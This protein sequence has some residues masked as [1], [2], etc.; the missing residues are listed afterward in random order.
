MR[1]K[2]VL[3]IVLGEFSQTTG[4][5]DGGTCG[6]GWRTDQDWERRPDSRPLFVPPGLL[7]PLDRIEWS[8]LSVGV[9]LHKRLLIR[10]RPWR[11]H[12]KARGD[13]CLSCH[14]LVMRTVGPFPPSVSSL[15]VGTGWYLLDISLISHSESLSLLPASIIYL[16]QLSPNVFQVKILSPRFND[17]GKLDSGMVVELGSIL[18]QILLPADI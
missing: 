16:P 3:F 18:K 15:T 1:T 17:F 13:V 10:T 2:A 9:S 5:G 14:L 8:Y 7:K 6:W 11:S 4:R 12:N